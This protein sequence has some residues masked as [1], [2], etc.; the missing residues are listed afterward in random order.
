VSLLAGQGAS[1]ALAGGRA[2]G[3]VQGE[4]AQIETALEQF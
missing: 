2:L 3:Q 1:L 4:G